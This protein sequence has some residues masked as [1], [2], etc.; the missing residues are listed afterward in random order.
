MLRGPPERVP[1]KHAELAQRDRVIP[2][3]K[4]PPP[5]GGWDFHIV[6]NL[7]ISLRGEGVL[8]AR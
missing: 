1:A 3:T 4:A 2:T 5:R 8:N 7:D 6:T